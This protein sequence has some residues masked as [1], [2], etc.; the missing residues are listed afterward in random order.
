[1]VIIFKQGRIY[2][3]QSE[4][5]IQS[6]TI[7]RPLTRSVSFCTLGLHPIHQYSPI[8]ICV[9]RVFLMPEEKS[10]SGVSA[11]K[12]SENKFR[13]NSAWNHVMRMLVIRVI[14]YK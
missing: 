14:P 9:V 5:E 6:F 8:S 3:R 10:R 13:D 1:M 7:P 4:K 12:L 2:Q 11:M